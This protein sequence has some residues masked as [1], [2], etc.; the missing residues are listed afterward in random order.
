V[1]VPIQFVS[2]VLPPSI[3]KEIRAAAARGVGIYGISAYYLRPPR[4]SGLLLGYSRLRER[5]IREGIRR[6]AELV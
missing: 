6:L 3:E 4:Q 1:N 2:H 5:E